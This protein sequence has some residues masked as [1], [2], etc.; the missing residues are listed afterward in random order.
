MWIAKDY[1]N[2]YPFYSSEM[3]S[4]SPAFMSWISMALHL[5]FKIPIS[6]MKSPLRWLITTV[7]MKVLS[8]F[9]MMMLMVSQIGFSY[10]TSLLL[11]LIPDRINAILS[12]MFSLNPKSVDRNF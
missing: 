9:G 4:L 12:S 6:L 3:S 1:S 11:A 7:R 10:K 5:V 8:G 2:F